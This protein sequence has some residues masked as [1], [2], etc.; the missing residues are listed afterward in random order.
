MV[1]TSKDQRRALKK[2]FDRSSL[3]KLD[4]HTLSFPNRH[5]GKPM[6]YKDFRKEVMPTF[7]MDDAVVV[8]WCG[9]WLCIEKDGYTHS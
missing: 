9:M 4:P 8:P 2:I 6:T 3:F 7:G 1:K 5:F